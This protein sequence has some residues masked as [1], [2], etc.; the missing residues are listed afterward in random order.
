MSSPDN[1]SVTT[2]LWYLF[3]IIVFGVCLCLSSTLLYAG[4]LDKAFDELRSP[5]AVVNTESQSQ[6][7]QNSFP[8][9]KPLTI[10]FVREKLWQKPG[11]TRINDMQSIEMDALVARTILGSMPVR[12]QEGLVTDLPQDPFKLARLLEATEGFKTPKA[13]QVLIQS[14]SD[15]RSSELP[16]SITDGWHLRVCDVAYNT[17]VH[18]R[19]LTQFRAPLGTSYALASRDRWIK[20]LQEWLEH[21]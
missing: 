20:Q 5:E 4:A 2:G 15:T 18:R 16:L 8:A 13:D 19:R 17:L 10:A 14:L 12:V 6:V 9:D 3:P 21:H 7:I 11:S 1:T